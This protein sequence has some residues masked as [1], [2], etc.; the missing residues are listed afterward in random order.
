MLSLYG[1]PGLREIALAAQIG[2]CSP[3]AFKILIARDKYSAVILGCTIF[4]SVFVCVDM[5]RVCLCV[6]GDGMEVCVGE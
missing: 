2:C 6:M 5:M 1:H 4:E 3:E